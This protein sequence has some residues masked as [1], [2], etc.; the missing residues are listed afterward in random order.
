[1]S[2]DCGC[3]QQ[4]PPLEGCGHQENVEG[5]CHR[6]AV[7]PCPGHFT[8]LSG[9]A[10]AAATPGRGDA[11]S[12]SR[13]FMELIQ[14][15]NRDGYIVS[16][17]YTWVALLGRYAVPPGRTPDETLRAMPPVPNVPPG[18]PEYLVQVGNLVGY[19]SRAAVAG[20]GATVSAVLEVAQDKLEG[21]GLLAFLASVAASAHVAVETNDDCTTDH[22]AMY[23]L[24]GSQVAEPVGLSV[25]PFAVDMV[26][27]Q[28]TGDVEAASNAFKS[29]L[30]LPG[31]RP[32][33][34]AVDVVSRTLGQLIVPGVSL[35]ATRGLPS[36]EGAV[37]GMVDLAV[38]SPENTSRELM[39]GVWAVRAA[40]A[41]AGATGPHDA[42]ERIRA[43]ARQHGKPFDFGMDVVLS[44]TQ[45]MGYMFH[46][47][48]AKPWTR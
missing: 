16:T 17:F 27:A 29:I 46:S 47:D 31:T 22:I 20:D 25:L 26:V 6:N 48:E 39:A 10:L 34:A 24:M 13:T 8:K 38:A 35:A 9:Q 3:D 40:E 12:D 21:E 19:V 7:I 23:H 18:S 45:M 43:V 42:T 37:Q 14:H 36:V 30:E 44:T 2:E 15:I 4:H 28:Q 11:L 5:A 33:A 41:Y 1:M 32:L